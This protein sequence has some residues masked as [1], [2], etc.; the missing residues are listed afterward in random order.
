MNITLLVCLHLTLGMLDTEN[1]LHFRVCYEKIRVLLFSQICD[2]FL[3]FDAY[4][5][6]IFKTGR[7]FAAHFICQ[8]WV[9]S[10]NITE[11]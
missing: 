2:D 3:L 7:L 9:G 8:A 10:Q 11:L 1:E 6:C 5:N 4:E